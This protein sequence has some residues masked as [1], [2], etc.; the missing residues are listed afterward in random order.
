MAVYSAAVVFFV[1]ERLSAPF[2]VEKAL[3]D[4]VYWLT[5][6]ALA[7]QQLTKQFYLLFPF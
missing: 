2:S 5:S 4:P 7:K 6:F 3:H 1:M